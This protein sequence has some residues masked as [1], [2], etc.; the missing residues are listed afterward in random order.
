MGI[1][2][3]FLAVSAAV[4][5]L[6]GSVS[7]QRVG[8][9]TTAQGHVTLA[10]AAAAPA[11]LRF[12]DEV[13]LRDRIST[14]EHSLARILFGGKAVVTVTERSV[15]TVTDS[16]KTSVIEMGPGRLTLAV[17][18]ERMGPG[19]A[20]EIRTPH[21]VAGVRGT[22]VVAEVLPAPNA[23][24]GY[25]SR[26]TVLKGLVDVLPV[27]PRTRVPISAAVPLRAREAVSVDRA[28]AT[29]RS[30]L[31][32]DAKQRLADEFSVKPSSEPAP[33]AAATSAVKATMVEQARDAA[34]KEVA[35]ILGDV[36]SDRSSEARAAKSGGDGSGKD[37]SSGKPSQDGHDAD[38]SKGTGG[39][40]K[41][42]VG[43]SS[44]QS[45]VPAVL[46]GDGVVP[47]V[48]GGQ[49][50]GGSDDT[51]PDTDVRSNGSNSGPDDDITSTRGKR[52]RDKGDRDRGSRRVDRSR[53]DRDNRD[54]RNGPDPVDNGRGTGP[55]LSHGPRSVDPRPSYEPSSPRP[56]APAI[57]SP[58][59][60]KVA[61]SVAVT[62]SL[63]VAPP[64]A[65]VAPVRVLPP[66]A[67]LPAAAPIV[68]PGPAASSA[69]P[70]VAEK[71]ASD[72]AKEAARES[73]RAAR[74]R[75]RH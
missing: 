7:A 55:S 4:A 20:I 74:D 59:V 65:V 69:V 49:R 68:A 34:V 31:S 15:L 9:V 11:P 21:A 2:P 51:G 1:R 73:R 37:G 52:G 43:Q 19:E 61:P 39:E 53:G 60:V 28:G 62:P 75:G 18:R 16:A 25:V 23:P 50:P 36:G 72:T 67:A 57:T 8:V 29:I 70:S 17:A 48:L 38:V 66:A 13:L 42:V 45:G 35:G 22:V 40:S 24:G 33:V 32:D 27:D 46:G 63:P 44:G 47:A 26:F 3:L 41:L 64:V 6:P 54:A 12:R 30:T 71:K 56:A 14:G 5:L 10:R 58:V